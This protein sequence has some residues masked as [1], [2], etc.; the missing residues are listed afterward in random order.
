MRTYR[1]VTFT[2][3]QHNLLNTMHQNKRYYGIDDTCPSCLIHSKTLTL[4][5]TCSAPASGHFRKEQQTHLWKK[6][7]SIG[8]PDPIQSAIQHGLLAW[9]SG[10]QRHHSPTKGS[11]NPMD[12]LITAAYYEQTQLGWEA[13]L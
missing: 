4:I 12:I 2:K 5:L 13:F 11:L 3:I 7:D 10:T 8:T 9:E 6:L 1:R